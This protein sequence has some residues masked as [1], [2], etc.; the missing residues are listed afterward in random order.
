MGRM[1]LIVGSLVLSFAITSL[2]VRLHS[3]Q[4]AHERRRL[5]YLKSLIEE[6]DRLRKL[7]ES[8]GFDD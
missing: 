4:K 5:E 7:D 1:F 3:E 2:A 8:L 6:S